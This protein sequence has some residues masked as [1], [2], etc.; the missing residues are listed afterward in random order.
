MLTSVV[1]WESSGGR[2]VV[3]VVSGHSIVHCLPVQ[4]LVEVREVWLGQDVLKGLLTTRP[5]NLAGGQIGI[6]KVGKVHIVHV[7]QKGYNS[8]GRN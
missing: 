4:K 2:N 7:C 5:N 6:V 8:K 1:D 3:L